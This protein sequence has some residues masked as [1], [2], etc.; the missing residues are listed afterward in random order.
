MKQGGKRLIPSPCRARRKARRRA[1]LKAL[2]CAMLVLALASGGLLAAYYAGLHRA[3]AQLEA[4]A[5][6]VEPA[7]QA[8]QPQHGAA[9]APS[10]SPPPADAPEA[11]PERLALYRPLAE[12]NPDLVGWIAIAGTAVN[13]PVMQ[14]PGDGRYYLTHG[15]DGGLAVG[16]LPFLDEGC[17]LDDPA[18]LVYGHYMKNGAIFTPLLSYRERDFWAEHPTV[19]LDTLAQER[20]YSV[21]AAF[22]ARVLRRDEAGFRYY[23]LPDGEESFAA[24]LEEIRAASVYDTGVQAQWGD[25]LLVLSTCSYHT[26]NGRFVVVARRDP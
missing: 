15:F 26:E 18:L 6:R 19:R 21:L 20:T 4:L 11:E 17:G 7:R 16:G 13:Y 5:R 12:E 3:N 9:T 10:G 8:L 25:Q 14:R 24:Y 23:A 1:A 22:P 2:L